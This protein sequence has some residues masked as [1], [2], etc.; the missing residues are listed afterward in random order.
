[1]AYDAELAAIR[2]GLQSLVARPDR[3]VDYTIFTDSQTAELRIQ[4]DAPEPGQASAIQA[5]QLPNLHG[6]GNT[7]IVKWVPGHKRDG[8]R[9][10]R[11]V[12][13]LGSGGPSDQLSR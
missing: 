5:I 3:G 8:Q 10:S 13:T 2:R 6:R 7:V 1:M 11:P 9:R 12:C 4:S